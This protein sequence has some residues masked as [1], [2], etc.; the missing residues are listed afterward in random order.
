MTI[1]YITQAV[2]DVNDSHQAIED[3]LKTISQ[4][5]EGNDT[6]CRV[7]DVLTPCVDN[8]TPI[9]SSS[10]AL[11][12]IFTESIY[13]RLGISPPAFPAME[14]F[15]SKN[16]NIPALRVSVETLKESLVELLKKLKDMF[17]KLWVRI[18]SFFEKL[19][20]ANERIKAHAES[21]FKDI[22]AMSSDKTPNSQ[23]VQNTA[24]RNFWSADG[25]LTLTMIQQVLKTHSELSDNTYEL[26]KSQLDALKT[27]KQSADAIKHNETDKAIQLM[28]ESEDILRDAIMQLGLYKRDHHEGNQMVE[29]PLIGH[30][31]LIGTTEHDADGNINGILWTKETRE[32]GT[33]RGIKPV[34]P[35]DMNEL[36]RQV[37][38]LA[39]TSLSTKQTLSSLEEVKTL[40]LYVSD[41][42]LKVL[43]SRDP[44][45]DALRAAKRLKSIVNQLVTSSYRI[46]V[47]MGDLNVKANKSALDCVTSLL[48]TYKYKKSNE[49]FV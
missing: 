23:L 17:L 41:E 32:A 34:K 30:T 47:L 8:N 4:I 45:D 26:I 12:S 31:F 10:V 28:L 24:M 38:Q 1:E 42:L 21:L 13:Q 46:S 36:L 20:D 44:S 3:D 7:T 33:V 6:L 49:L 27:L 18:K 40:G 22:D 2:I 39:D 15:T 37:I 35:Q 25:V 16:T 5:E 11:L 14:S 43:S 29:G 48:R 9:T 19:F